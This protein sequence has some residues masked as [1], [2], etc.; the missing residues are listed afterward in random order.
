MQINNERGASIVSLLY[1]QRVSPHRRFWRFF[2]DAS[3]TTQKPNFTK[4]P[5]SSG[6]LQKSGYGNG[7][8]DETH[9]N[10]HSGSRARQACQ[11]R[12]CATGETEYTRRLA[13]VDLSTQRS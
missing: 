5:S 7:S 4:Q 9:F 6:R 3:R 2:G 13:A 12:V 10:P 1:V 11:G 8:K